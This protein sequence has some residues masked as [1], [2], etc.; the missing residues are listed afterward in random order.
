ME[1]RG[2]NVP[3]APMKGQSR[4]WHLALA[5]LGSGCSARSARPCKSAAVHA[6]K[7]YSDTTS[8]WKP[9]DTIPR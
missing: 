9:S 4:H 1:R 2:P 6:R 8:P 3:P 5:H 7:L